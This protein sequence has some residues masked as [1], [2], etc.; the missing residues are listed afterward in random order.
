MKLMHMLAMGLAITPLLIPIAQAQNQGGDPWPDMKKLLVIADV[1]TGFHHDS[2]NHAMGVIE[3]LGR[4][5]GAW[6][7]ILRTDSQLITKEEI[8]GQGSRYSGRRVNARNLNYFDGVFVLASG[9]GTLNEE[10]KSALLSFV[11]DDGKAIILGHAASVAWY[12]WQDYLDMIGSFMASEYRTGE[13]QFIRE[14]S[15]FPGANAFA[16][17]FVLNDQ[18]AVWLDHFSSDDAEVILRMDPAG[19]TEEQ[20][21]TRADH[22]FPEVFAKYYG[23]GR[24]FNNAIGHREEVW[25]DPRFRELMTEGIK[26]ALGVTQYDLTYPN[27]HEQ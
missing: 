4:E 14:S 2:I 25:D 20:L 11:H 16:E 1:Q 24:V 13:F 19:M 10:Q 9:E 7:T 27:K 17:H 5:S 18:P 22:D 12:D 8:L 3:Q 21:A 23:K 26:W 6:V 15:T